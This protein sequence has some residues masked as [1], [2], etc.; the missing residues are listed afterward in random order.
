MRYP[1]PPAEHRMTL[2]VLTGLVERLTG[3]GQHTTGGRDVTLVH[4]ISADPV[5]L[6][7]LLGIYLARADEDPHYAEAVRL[8]RAA[9]ADEATANTMAA[10]SRQQRVKQGEEANIKR[11]PG[12]R[13]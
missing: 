7:H 1:A 10:W 5:A 8:L 13:P 4:E 2:A 3:G 9:G 6:G 12:G 11:G